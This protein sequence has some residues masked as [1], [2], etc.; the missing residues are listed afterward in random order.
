MLKPW[1]KL[2]FISS[3]HIHVISHLR[4]DGMARGGAESPKSGT[5]D[6]AASYP[7]VRMMLYL[8]ASLPSVAVGR[9]PELDQALRGAETHRSV[10]R[11]LTR[12]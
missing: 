2:G 8:P 7:G 5:Q 11:P 4:E 9:T 6:R 12:V 1:C 10:P 3:G